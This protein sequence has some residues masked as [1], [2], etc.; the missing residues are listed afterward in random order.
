M[1]A[2]NRDLRNI[3]FFT[4]A[5]SSTTPQIDCYPASSAIDIDLYKKVNNFDNA[6]RKSPS[7]SKVISRSASVESKTSSISYYKGIVI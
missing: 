5:F 6:R 7:L 4:S 2:L 1:V 3:Q